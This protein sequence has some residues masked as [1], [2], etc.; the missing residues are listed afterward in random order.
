LLLILEPLPFLHT[1]SCSLKLVADPKVGK[2]YALD[3]EGSTPSDVRQRI[4]LRDRGLDPSVVDSPKV[5]LLE[6][7]VSQPKLGLADELYER[8]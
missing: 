5:T 1:M 4:V 2:V 3:R 6:G 7:T 8:F